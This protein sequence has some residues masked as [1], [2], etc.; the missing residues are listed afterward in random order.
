[1][2]RRRCPVSHRTECSIDHA[3]LES[4]PPDMNS[5]DDSIIGP[6]HHGQAVSGLNTQ[7][8]I[9]R[10]CH[11]SI[12][13]GP[14]HDIDSKFID[15]ETERPVNL[16]KPNPRSTTDALPASLEHWS[17]SCDGK[18][19]V[20]SFCRPDADRAPVRERSINEP[21]GGGKELLKERRDVEIAVVV[22]IVVG[23]EDVTCDRT[24]VAR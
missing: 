20:G 21:H 11:Y 18:V 24:I 2:N 4:T 9:R 8:D 13:F 6:Q 7:S 17:R 15:I 14:N 12:G 16:T 1:V 10:R 19:T 22:E 3:R 5:G 23:G